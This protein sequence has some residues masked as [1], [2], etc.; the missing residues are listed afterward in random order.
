MPAV[1]DQNSHHVRIIIL[2]VSNPHQNFTANSHFGRRQ[3]AS[4]HP[5]SCQGKSSYQQ[6]V[7]AAQT[8]GTNPAG[9]GVKG[10]GVGTTAP[11]DA[12]ERVFGKNPI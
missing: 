10:K 9:A 2:G 5:A 11:V 3:I 7:L 4:C 6:E 12:Y 8:R 1:L